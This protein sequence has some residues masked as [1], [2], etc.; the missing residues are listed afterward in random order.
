MG[1]YVIVVSDRERVY[2]KK[3]KVYKCKLPGTVAPN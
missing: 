2:I 3:A 1:I